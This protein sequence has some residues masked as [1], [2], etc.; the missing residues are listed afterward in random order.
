M[1]YD[2]EGN[3]VKTSAPKETRNFNGK[4]YV[5]EHALTADFALVRAKIAD[6]F[7]NLVFS[8]T[9][10]NLDPMMAMAAKTTLVEVE[11]WLG[12]ET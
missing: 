3:V 5:L 12:S 7:G 9:A 1:R 10:R 8:K 11:K 4:D 2:K 6:P